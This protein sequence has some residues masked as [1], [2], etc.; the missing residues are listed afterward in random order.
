MKARKNRKVE[1]FFFDF[2][3]DEDN[4]GIEFQAYFQ[5]C[6]SAIKSGY[7]ESE[8]YDDDDYRVERMK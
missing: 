4:P 6:Q 3:I 2:D 8:G 5:E 1:Q 7:L